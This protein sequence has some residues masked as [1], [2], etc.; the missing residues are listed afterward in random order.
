MK[1]TEEQIFQALVLF[2]D[3]A[4][5]E[6][7]IRLAERNTGLKFEQLKSIAVERLI[8]LVPTDEGEFHLLQAHYWKERAQ[9]MF[10][11]NLS[12]AAVTC[13]DK[14]ET[15]ILSYMSMRKEGKLVG[16][17]PSIDEINAEI[18]KFLCKV[19]EKYGIPLNRIE[20]VRRVIENRQPR[21]IEGVINR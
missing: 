9:E 3:G 16:L 15:H 13:M 11:K 8:L 19:S 7:R 14:Y 1:A 10:S 5:T 18:V 2:S 17:K 20:D 4:P 21:V 6:G 12:T